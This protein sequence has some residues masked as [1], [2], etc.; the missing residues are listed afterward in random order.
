[1]FNTN[2][3]FPRRT[4]RTV[5]DPNSGSVFEFFKFRSTKTGE[6]QRSR[7]SR[8]NLF[9]SSFRQKKNEEY[10]LFRL[11]KTSNRCCNRWFC[12]FTSLNPKRRNP[13][14]SIF[15]SWKNF[16]EKLSFFFSSKFVSF[17][18]KIF[19]TEFSICCVCSATNR[20]AI[21]SSF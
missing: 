16:R 3:I 20:A 5:S 10:F 11:K 15:A 4:Y 1:M 7:F 21:K 19:R 18:R 14:S 17:D 12:F 13:E 9:F 8:K 6:K 2:E